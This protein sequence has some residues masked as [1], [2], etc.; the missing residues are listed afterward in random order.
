MAKQGRAQEWKAEGQELLDTEVFWGTLITHRMEGLADNPDYVF[1][2]DSIVIAEG[3]EF[4]GLDE[5]F[6]QYT[7]KVGLLGLEYEPISMFSTDNSNATIRTIL[8]HMKLPEQ[9]PDGGRWVDIFGITWDQPAAFAPGWGN[10][11]DLGE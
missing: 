10:I 8:H 9:R 2:V 7:R 3:P 6:T 11:F 4:C 5:K 1:M